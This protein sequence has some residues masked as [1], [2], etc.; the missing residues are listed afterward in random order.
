MGCDNVE[1]SG[2]KIDDCDVCGGSNQCYG[3]DGQRDN[4]KYDMVWWKCT[5]VL[6]FQCGSCVDP[7]DACVGVCDGIPWST[8]TVDE[9]GMCGGKNE[10]AGCD[11]V[12]NS[13]RAYDIV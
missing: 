9:C 8:A 13:G 3:C 4:R 1:W 2:A 5:I 7:V 6:T 10:C 11:G 12:L